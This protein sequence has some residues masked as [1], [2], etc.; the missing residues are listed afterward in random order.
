LV[1]LLLAL[2]LLI[3]WPLTLLADDPLSPLAVANQAPIVGRH[4]KLYDTVQQNLPD[5]QGFSYLSVPVG[6]TVAFSKGATLLDTT[7]NDFQAGFGRQDQ[8]LNRANGFTIRFYAQVLSETHANNNRAGFSI[9]ALGSD[10]QGIELGFW[11]N[12]IWAQEGGTAPNLF[13]HA[14][15]A[16]FT[17][18]AA[19]Y[20]YELTI[21]GNTYA[22]AVTDTFIL[23]G[24]V[25]DYTAFT[26]IPDVYETPNFIFLGDDTNLA[27]AS[28]R[29][30]T[31]S[32]I[33]GNVPATHT[34]GL[35]QTLAVND[36]GV[37]DGDAAGQNEVLTLSV[38]NGI[39]SLTTNLPN[40]LSSGQ[41]SGN[42]SGT[43]VLTGSVGRMNSTLHQ[44]SAL[45]YQPQANFSGLDPLTMTL[46]DQGHSD[47]GNL[48]ATQIISIT[49]FGSPTPTPSP[50]PTPLLKTIFLPVILKG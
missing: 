14:E 25:R 11:S 32:L 47:G 42:G 21:R 3:L 24:T 23:S 29:L 40:G 39:L 43:L 8:T 46:N 7:G 38:A 18:T 19:L 41:V 13:K 20:P 27:R 1:T 28:V 9:I 12:E 10:K 22:L 4:L 33:D 31:I 50:S 35:T 2:L 45:I 5:A 26:G 49:V 36:L 6:A 17:T 16:A 15:G 34:I 44:P 37:L 30:G 48:S